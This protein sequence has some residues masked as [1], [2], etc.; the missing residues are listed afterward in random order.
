M[1]NISQ[2]DEAEQHIF[3][4]VLQN[5][6][7]AFIEDLPQQ[8]TTLENAILSLDDPGAF[9]ARFED[10]Y[11]L[12]L[13]I[14]SRAST[15]DLEAVSLV[16][17]RMADRLHGINGRHSNYREADTDMLL[18]HVDLLRQVLSMVQQEANPAE[19]IAHLL[20]NHEPDRLPKTM[21]VLIVEH[22]P[23]ILNKC[24]QGLE[25]YPTSVAVLDNGFD[26]ID[27]LL[28]EPFD[29]LIC[30]MELPKLN[31]VALIHAVRWSRGLNANIKTILLTSSQ[32][33]PR[34][35]EPVDFTIAKDESFPKRYAEALKRVF[36][37]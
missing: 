22:S 6:K 7:T 23:M 37:A 27:R 24:K 18:D 20:V 32:P 14:R 33:E 25:D 19:I 11:R 15:F 31:G 2:H 28:R 36:S 35:T 1:S 26:A 17:E 21:R 4:H 3:K 34:S 13:Q 10:L 8:V 16:C 30:S 29:L 12:L 5:L 9:R